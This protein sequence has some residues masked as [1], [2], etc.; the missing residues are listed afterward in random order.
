MSTIREEFDFG[1]RKS[2]SG[3]IAEGDWYG[4]EVEIMTAN[5]APHD[6]ALATL[7]DLHRNWRGWKIDLR[8]ALDDQYGTPG[9][10]WLEAI[11]AFANGRFEI[12][13]SAPSLFGDDIA[14]AAG[15]LKGGFDEIAV[16]D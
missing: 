7:S 8:D 11:T 10:Y 4:D 9:N 13:L 6:D 12:E 1:P 2:G 3:L 5:T 15:T 14:V 16:A